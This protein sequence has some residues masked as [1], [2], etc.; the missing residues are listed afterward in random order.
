MSSD[1]IIVRSF[2]FLF[3]PRSDHTPIA[4]AQKQSPIHSFRPSVR[5]LLRSTSTSTSHTQN[6]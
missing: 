6:E 4:N 2:S 1:E 3:L 5:P